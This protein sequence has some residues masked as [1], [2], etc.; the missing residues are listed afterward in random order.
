MLTPLPFCSLQSVYVSHSLYLVNHSVNLP[1]SVAAAIFVAGYLAICINYDADRQRAVARATGGDCLIWGRKPDMIR[2]T[3]TTET[4]ERKSS[5]LLASGW[6]AVSRHFHYVPE[7]TAA[8]LWSA[9]S[10]F[11]AFLPYFYFVFLFPLLM[12]R[13]EFGVC[14]FPLLMD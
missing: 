11:G 4:G 13:G 12:D 10:G 7:L 14:L 5:L 8:L 2:A 3:Y 9:P 6:W 1:F